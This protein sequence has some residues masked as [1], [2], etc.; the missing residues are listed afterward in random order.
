MDVETCTFCGDFTPDENFYE[1][2]DSFVC[3]K[4]D[5]QNLAAEAAKAQ[6]TANEDASMDDF[7]EIIDDLDR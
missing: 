5:C 3:G 1:A 4:A 2:L 6:G 7:D